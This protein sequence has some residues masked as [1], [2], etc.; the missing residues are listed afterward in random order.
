MIKNNGR[1]TME[2]TVVVHIV[3]YYCH[4]SCL[5]KKS[6]TYRIIKLKTCSVNFLFYWTVSL[7]H[8]S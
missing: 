7:A 4:S 8:F 2:I 1:V 6:A 3:S 5:K